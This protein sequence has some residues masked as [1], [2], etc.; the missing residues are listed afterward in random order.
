LRVLYPATDGEPGYSHRDLEYKNKK[1]IGLTTQ[2]RFGIPNSIIGKQQS[3][4]F[5]QVL[6]LKEEAELVSCQ[7]KSKEPGQPCQ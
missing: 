4:V 2:L 7:L 6:K 3:D 1:K 5:L